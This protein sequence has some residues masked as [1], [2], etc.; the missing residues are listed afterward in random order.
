MQ[1]NHI[2]VSKTARFFTHGHEDAP[3][4]W[5][6]LHG[7]GMTAFSMLKSVEG[8]PENNYLWVAPEGLSRFYWNGFSGPVVA[9]WMTKD[10]RENEI[11][12]YVA[13]L[14]ALNAKV[15]AKQKPINILGFSQG[16]ATACR[17]LAYSPL[18]FNKIVL[19]AGEPPSDIDYQ[20]QQHKFK[21]L[22][23]VYGKDDPFIQPA[24]IEK[25]QTL[26]EAAKIDFELISFEGKHELKKEVMT[27]IIS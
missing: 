3:E 16:V 23:V 5:Y 8:E 25:I 12:N 18:T 13:Y 24:Q 10:D 9:S 14:N 11:R 1:E 15:N 20:Q 4:I 19:W 17:W 2:E 7:Y 6:L 21:S 27:S 22:T 26:F